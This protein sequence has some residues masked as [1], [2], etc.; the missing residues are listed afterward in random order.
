VHEASGDGNPDLDIKVRDGKVLLHCQSRGCANDAIVAELKARKLWLDRGERRRAQRLTLAQFAAAKKLPIEF[1]L[2]NDVSESTSR[3]Q[4]VLHFRCRREDGSLAPRYR[5]RVAMD[6]PRKFFWDRD[7]AEPITAYG[8]PHLQAVRTSTD[9]DAFLVLAEGESDA[10]TLRHHGI[11]ALGFPGASTVNKLLTPRLL[12]GISKLIVSVE[13]GDAGRKFLDDIM[14]RLKL[15]GWAGKLRL[16][17]WPPDCKD[18][19]ALHIKDHDGFVEEFRRL[20]KASE[21]INLTSTTPPTVVDAGAYLPHTTAAAWDALRAAN[22]AR[23]IPRIFNYDGV[24]VRVEM[25][26]DTP[27]MRSLGEREMRG[28]MVRAALFLK[29]DVEPTTP[30]RELVQDVLQVE[31]KPVPLLRRV[32][33]VPIFARDGTLIGTPGFYR[34]AGILY[35]PERG[36]IVPEVVEEPTEDERLSAYNL[37]AEM[38]AGFPFASGPS[39]ADRAHA[40]ALILLPFVREMIDGSTPIHFAQAPTPRTGKGLLVEQALYVGL[41]NG[42]Q[43]LGPPPESEYQFE[44]AISTGIRAGSRAF[45]F[46]NIVK[47]LDSAYLAQLVTKPFWTAR[48]LS[49]NDNLRVDPFDPIWVIA[50]NNPQISDEL[51]GRSIRIRLD[52]KMADPENRIFDVDLRAW[53]KLNRARLIH[54]VLTLV[55]HWIIDGKKKPKVTPLGNFENWTRVMG[56]ILEAAGIEGLLAIRPSDLKRR[57]NSEGA[58][59]AEFVAQWWDRFENNEVTVAQ[60]W[61]I[62]REIEGFWL[63][64]SETEK[65]QQTSLGSTLSRRIDQVVEPT[66][67][68]PTDENSCPRKRP[69]CLRIVY[70]GTAKRRGGWILEKLEGN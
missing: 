61:P 35:L 7:S 41:G 67:I 46:D 57:S 28:E 52:A 70:T 30:D 62:A 27:I 42:Y 32:T 6:G 34:E 16:L 39:G 66:Q 3:N 18:P 63:G 51:H 5:V 29:D 38:L 58:A 37:I 69:A 15:F 21:Q 19:S 59:W 53:V 4:P 24:L 13:P 64:R 45:F 54:A 65:G 25:D 56:G 40:I 47:F 2:A 55:Q 11:A 33:G 26:R 50:G 22:D 17:K 9:A 12:E 10:L 36:L 14:S 60:L 48:L 43:H 23:A 31:N 44:Q 49:T 68:E 20:V 8:L 1:L